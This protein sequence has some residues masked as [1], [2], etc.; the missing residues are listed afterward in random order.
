MYIIIIS[1]YLSC[2]DNA[3]NAT[4]IRKKNT[5]KNEQTVRHITA[6]YRVNRVNY[7]FYVLV[8]PAFQ[9]LFSFHCGKRYNV[10]EVFTAAAV[11]GAWLTRPED[12]SCIRQCFILHAGAPQQASIAT[13]LNCLA[14][15]LWLLADTSQGIEGK[16]S[17]LAPYICSLVSSMTCALGCGLANFNN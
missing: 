5:W 11:S 13:G 17:H 2:Y 16:L 14:E 9:R 8:L 3:R 6:Y 12:D 4:M 7:T 1:C 15:S 10:T